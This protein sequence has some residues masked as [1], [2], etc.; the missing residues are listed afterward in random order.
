MS[1]DGQYRHFAIPRGRSK[2][3][4]SNKERRS[5]H[6]SRKRNREKQLSIFLERDQNAVAGKNGDREQFACS[7]PKQRAIAALSGETRFEV[8]SDYRCRS[9]ITL[10]QRRV[11]HCFSAPTHSCR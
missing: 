10:E 5:L 2:R 8:G 1:R 4:K 7:A 11:R 9:V 3:T 6:V